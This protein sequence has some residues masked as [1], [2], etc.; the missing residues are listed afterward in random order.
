MGFEEGA[1]Q[2][3]CQRIRADQRMDGEGFD[4]EFFRPGENGARGE[5]FVLLDSAHEQVLWFRHRPNLDR[6]HTC[7]VNPTAHLDDII[8]EI[9]VTPVSPVTSTGV[10]RLVVELSPICP[11]PL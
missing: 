2:L 7:R 3:F 10:V 5:A 4:R 1:D 8:V 6:A 9:E 11:K